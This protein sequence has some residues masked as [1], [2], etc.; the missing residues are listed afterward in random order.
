MCS[1]TSQLGENHSALLNELQQW[2]HKTTF[3]LQQAAALQATTIPWEYIYEQRLS[4]DVENAP[5][6]CAHM[7]QFLD[8]SW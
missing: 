1:V 7:S 6:P 8:P 2:S 4:V 3:P 5:P